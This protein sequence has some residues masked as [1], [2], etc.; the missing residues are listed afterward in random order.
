MENTSTKQSPENKRVNTRLSTCIKAVT[1]FEEYIKLVEREKQDNIER[2][3]TL[4]RYYFYNLLTD[5]FG[6]S[7]DYI[8]TL[9]KKVFEIKKTITFTD[10]DILD[11][12]QR[13]KL[14]YTMMNS[15]G[16]N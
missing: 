6:Y 4:P 7:S 8:A 9:L 10:A 15:Q 3:K 2:Y 11:E 16:G 5:K 12:I 1:L 13:D 14:I